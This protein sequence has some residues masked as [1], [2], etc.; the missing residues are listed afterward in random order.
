SEEYL[1]RLLIEHLAKG[2]EGNFEDIANLCMMLHQRGAHPRV[3]A[4][5]LATAGKPAPSGW[6]PIE[7]A[8][9]DGR[10]ILVYEARS[11]DPIHLRSADGDWWRKQGVGPS[12]WMPLPTPPTAG[13]GD[14]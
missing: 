8:P 14:A 2:N 11:A 12:H 10:M 3:L 7:T 9:A 4:A 13:G 1:A 6:L 5:A